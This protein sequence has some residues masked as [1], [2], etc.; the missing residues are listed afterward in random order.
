[1]ATPVLQ[2]C[3]AVLSLTLKARLPS[4]QDSCNASSC[5]SSSFSRPNESNDEFSSNDF[6]M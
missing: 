3:Q 1:V 4:L 6:P 2:V 5:S